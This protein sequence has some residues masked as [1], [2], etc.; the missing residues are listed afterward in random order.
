MQSVSRQIEIARLAG[1]VQVCKGESDS[2]SWP[3]A[4]CQYGYQLEERVS[5]LSRG[6]ASHTGDGG[7]P[8]ENGME[9]VCY[10]FILFTLYFT[11]IL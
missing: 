7:T 9:M 2:G 3:L 1:D 10:E 6:D 8:A 5:G 11:I 4:W